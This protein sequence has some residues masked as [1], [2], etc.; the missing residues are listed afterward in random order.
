M[1]VKRVKECK[2]EPKECRRVKEYTDTYLSTYNKTMYT[3]PI[4][5]VIIRISKGGYG[6][7]DCKMITSTVVC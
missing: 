6:L 2:Q 1:N 3:P 7:D 4:L 5:R